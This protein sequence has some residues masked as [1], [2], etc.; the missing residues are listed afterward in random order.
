MVKS[1]SPVI[2]VSRIFSGMFCDNNVPFIMNLF[3]CANILY[4]VLSL[5]IVANKLPRV[6]SV[7]ESVWAF[8]F[9]EYTKLLY[10]LP[11]YIKVLAYNDIFTGSS[12]NVRIG[13]FVKNSSSVKL[14]IKFLFE[15]ESIDNTCVQCYCF[16][17]YRT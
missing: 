14:S 4:F 12:N 5:F 3:S 1:N 17:R 6:L 7:I 9:S 13:S 15:N 10:L 2:I 8:D 16:V 11:W